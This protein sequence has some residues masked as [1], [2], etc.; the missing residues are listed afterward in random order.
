MTTTASVLEQLTVLRTLTT[1]ELRAK[2][3]E[4]FGED[5]T[6]R[7][8]PYLFRKLAGEIQARAERAEGERIPAAPAADDKPARCRRAPRAASA[9]DP[10]LPPAGTVLERAFGGRT[11][12]VTVLEQGF[13]YAGTTW[14]SL[15]AIARSIAGGTSWNGLLF[16]KLIPYAKRA[17]PAA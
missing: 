14:R 13:E 2:H 10:R 1:S 4:L 12:Q 3:R 16:F 8:K 5:T 17:K 9:R 7:N 15:S 6:T 11:H